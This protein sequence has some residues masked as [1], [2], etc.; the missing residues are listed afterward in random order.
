MAP[1]AKRVVISRFHDVS[2]L[3]SFDSE[4][5]DLSLTGQVNSSLK[6]C[7]VAAG[8]YDFYPRMGPTSLWDTAAAQIIVEQAGGQVVDF[9]GQRLQYHLESGLLNP[10]FIAVGDVSIVNDVLEFCAMLRRGR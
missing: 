6:F 1:A 8:L 2:R 9:T 4:F 5:I 3:A 7:L 10:E